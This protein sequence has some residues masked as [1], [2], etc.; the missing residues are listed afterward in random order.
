MT[1]AS[2]PPSRG[3]C[4]QIP[5]PSSSP[6]EPVANVTCLNIENAGRCQEKLETCWLFNQWKL[7]TCWLVY[8]TCFFILIHGEKPHETVEFFGTSEYWVFGWSMDWLN[9]FE[10][11]MYGKL[12]KPLVLPSGYLT[13]CHG[14]SS[15][16]IGKPSISMA[17]F[18][19][20]CQI[21]GGYLWFFLGN[22]GV[23]HMTKTLWLWDGWRAVSSSQRTMNLDFFGGS[24][25]RNLRDPHFWTLNPPKMVF[26]DDHWVMFCSKI[27]GGRLGSTDHSTCHAGLPASLLIHE[28]DVLP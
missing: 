16:L 25:F 7:E 5:P 18:P 8:P 12:Q 13:V 1:L 21:T 11:I 3:V 20:L 14:K 2:F 24:M 10:D 17:H 9:W 23:L 22:M 4:M 26:Y 28:S 15:F 19:W 6:A 27:L